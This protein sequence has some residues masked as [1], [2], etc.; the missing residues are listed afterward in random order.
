MKQQILRAIV[1]CTACLVLGAQ[2][3]SSSSSSGSTESSPSGSQGSQSSGAYGQ[4]S[5]WMGRHMG[6]TGRMGQ[7]DMKAS[8]L[9]GCEIKSSSGEKLGTI[10]DQV[11]NPATG[12]IVF[13][14]VS[15]SSSSSSSGAATSPSGST[16][17]SSENPSGGATTPSESSSSSSSGGNKDVAVPWLLLRPSG[18]PGGTPSFTFIGDQSKLQSAPAFEESTD[19]SKASWRQ[20]VFSYYGLTQPGAA[21]G[22]A[23]SPGGTSSGG[24]SGDSQQNPGSSGNP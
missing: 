16:S 18:Q 6:A 4:S 23:E 1:F 3:Q 12:R 8:Q 14:I 15:L 20:S 5:G 7:Y 21:T 9:K 22:G 19:V 11:I 17:G 24:T 10:N 13:A 2:A